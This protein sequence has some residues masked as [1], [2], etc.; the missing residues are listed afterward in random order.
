[1]I[2][3]AYRRQ[4]K[5]HHPD[6]GGNSADFRKIQ[7]AYEALIHWVENPVFSK[8][9]GF[10]DKWFYEGMRN[11]WVQPTPLNGTS[12]QGRKQMADKRDDFDY[13]LLCKREHSEIVIESIQSSND[14]NV[15]FENDDVIIFEWLESQG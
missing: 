9:R 4:A 10:P 12:W 7:A 1:M 5:V 8:R 14:S 2:K 11:Q 13:L 15:V 6:L 3:S